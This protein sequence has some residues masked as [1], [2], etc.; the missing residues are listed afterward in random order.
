MKTRDVNALNFAFGYAC[1]VAQA[2]DTRRTQWNRLR[3][4]RS[5]AAGY[6][7]GRDAVWRANLMA[8]VASAQ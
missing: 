5:E 6:D 1:R 3:K 4:V 7:L 8:N 2:P